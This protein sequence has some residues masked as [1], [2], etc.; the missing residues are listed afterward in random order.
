MSGRTLP[1]A[2]LILGVVTLIMLVLLSSSPEVRAV[3]S[4]SDVGLAVSA[5]QRAETPADIAAVFGDPA[6]PARVAAMDALNTLD[7]WGFIPAYTLFLCVAAL[8]LGGSSVWR[9][10][11]IAFALIGAGADAVETWRQLE[12]TANIQ[13]PQANLPIAPWHWAKY[14]ALALNGWAVAAMCYL[15]EK[16]RR[17][18]GVLA[19]LPLP[20]V[21]LA[22]FDVTSPRLFSLAFG[23]FWI[24]LL[25]TAAWGLFRKRA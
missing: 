15:G 8:W 10:G 4:S 9:W 5:F 1:L 16:P 6:D 24:G 21:A 2:T 12:L 20:M 19:A 7:L 17:I 3:Y 22:Y 18:L 25:V 14:L 23:L 13:N 11:A